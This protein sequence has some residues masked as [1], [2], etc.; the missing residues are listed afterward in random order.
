LAKRV[1]KEKQVS[2][3]IALE[4]PQ[5]PENL[6][7]V[8]DTSGKTDS[9][10]E[11]DKLSIDEQFGQDQK[12]EADESEG[13][14]EE[15]VFSIED[16]ENDIGCLNRH[17]F[18]I[19]ENTIS[20]QK[21][22]LWSKYTNKAELTLKLNL[23]VLLKTYYLNQGQLEECSKVTLTSILDFEDPK[24]VSLLEGLDNPSEIGGKISQL[25]KNVTL[26]NGQILRNTNLITHVAKDK[27][28]VST[29][30]IL[31]AIQLAQMKMVKDIESLKENQVNPKENHD[32]LNTFVTIKDLQDIVEELNISI[33]AKLLK[34]QKTSTDMYPFG[35]DPSL[36]KLV[37]KDADLTKEEIQLACKAC[38]SFGDPVVAAVLLDVLGINLTNPDPCKNLSDFA[39]NLVTPLAVQEPEPRIKQKVQ[40]ARALGSWDILLNNLVNPGMMSASSLMEETR[41]TLLA[42]QDI[43]AEKLAFGT[44]VKSIGMLF[45]AGSQNQPNNDHVL[46]RI[47]ELRPNLPSKNAA[48]FKPW[49]KD[50]FTWSTGM[51]NWSKDKMPVGKPTVFVDIN[52]P[53]DKQLTT[54]AFQKD[55]AYTSV[56]GNNK[57]HQKFNTKR[58]DTKPRANPTGHS[59]LSVL[60]I[61]QRNSKRNPKN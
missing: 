58:N 11:E 50:K 28:N 49:P 46:Q 61:C 13:E 7:I 22:S 6:E 24:I 16:L 35:Y 30:P 32:G 29:K 14:V 36:S 34:G 26:L 60:E 59:G 25:E 40:F 43:C 21:D 15:I 3:G 10:I 48:S 2:E 18:G 1:K 17:L 20:Y 53:N 23:K 44:K 41:I 55:F 47:Y 5:S 8:Y 51:K 4:E 31:N 19:L 9:M 39:K 12:S 37:K 38:I 27:N 57:N 56:S 52:S 42:L 45:T 54:A 33:E